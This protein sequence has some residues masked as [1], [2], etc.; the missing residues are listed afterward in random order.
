M[1]EETRK[2]APLVTRE[3]FAKLC[4]RKVRRHR[5]S[6]RAR[7]PAPVWISEPSL[8][9]LRPYR[10][11]PDGGYALADRRPT[12]REAQRTQPVLSRCTTTQGSEETQEKDT[13]LRRKSARSFPLNWSG[14]CYL[15][16][17]GIR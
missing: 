13:P 16:K 7:A 4:E 1:T 15:I 9:D 17:Q 12:D 10:Q 14:Y 6:A 5:L 11:L 2:R 3:G 8:P